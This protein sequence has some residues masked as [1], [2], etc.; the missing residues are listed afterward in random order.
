MQIG[1]VAEQVGLSLRTVRYYEEVGL[2]TPVGRS[3]GGFRIYDDS[4]VKRLELVRDLKP[5]GFSLEEIR[6]IV[7]LVLDPG[8]APYADLIGTYV[9]RARRE[10]KLA[11]RSLGAAERIIERLEGI[12][13]EGR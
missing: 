5:L 10:H 3:S 13:A 12:S 8:S 2:V 7:A 6:G 1:E 4:A 9:E 11:L